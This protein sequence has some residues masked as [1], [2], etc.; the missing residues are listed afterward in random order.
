MICTNGIS[1]W[2]ANCKFVLFELNRSMIYFIYF[3]RGMKGKLINRTLPCEKQREKMYLFVCVKEIERVN[4]E[5]MCKESQ[6]ERNILTMAESAIEY[7][8]VDNLYAFLPYFMRA[9]CV[10][11]PLS[12]CIVSFSLFLTTNMLPPTVSCRPCVAL[13]VNYVY[14][15][16]ANNLLLC[17]TLGR[18]LF[19]FLFLQFRWNLCFV[20]CWLTCYNLAK[21][22]LH[23]NLFGL[24]QFDLSS[25][26]V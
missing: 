8:I 24:W 25:N 19:K 5:S 20:H 6:K 14:I 16:Q 22:I 23:T 9:I 17:L 4:I 2:H 13:L 26:Q 15:S 11:F 1:K 10:V 7:S 3:N 18:S 21:C 12:L